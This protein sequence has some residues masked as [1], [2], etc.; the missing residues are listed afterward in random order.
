M[1]PLLQEFTVDDLLM[2]TG[3]VEDYPFQSPGTMWV[4]LISGRKQWYSAL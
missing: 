2:L 1:P 3:H 4:A